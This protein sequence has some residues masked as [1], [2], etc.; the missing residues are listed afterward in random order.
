[1]DQ[2]CPARSL[3]CAAAPSVLADRAGSNDIPGND[4]RNLIA[5]SANMHHDQR[6]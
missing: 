4:F 1:M 6:R 5:F 2:A 3:L